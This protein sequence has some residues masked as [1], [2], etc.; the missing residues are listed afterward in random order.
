MVDLSTNINTDNELCQVDMSWTYKTKNFSP[1]VI[2]N[3]YTNKNYY[4][5]F[6]RQATYTQIYFRIPQQNQFPGPMGS[7]YWDVKRY[8]RVGG[9]NTVEKWRI[10]RQGNSGTDL[11]PPNIKGTLTDKT[12][13]GWNGVAFHILGDGQLCLDLH[14]K[15]FLKQDELCDLSSMKIPY[16]GNNFIVA[17]DSAIVEKRKNFLYPTMRRSLICINSATSISQVTKFIAK[18]NELG[19]DKTMKTLTPRDTVA[20]YS[21][22]T[23]TKVNLNAASC[24]L[25]G[26]QGIYID[27]SNND[28]IGRVDS[29]SI[30]VISENP[31]K[32]QYS[33]YEYLP[34]DVVHFLHYNNTYNV[35]V[36]FDEGGMYIDPSNVHGIQTYKGILEN[37]S[38]LANN[39][40]F[41]MSL[42]KIPYTGNNFIVA[43]KS[44]IRT[45]RITE[46]NEVYRLNPMIAFNG[47]ICKTNELGLDKTISGLSSIKENVKVRQISSTSDI[48]LSMNTSGHSPKY[49]ITSTQAFYMKFRDINKDVKIKQHVPGVAN[50]SWFNNNMAF[51]IRFIEQSPNK[52]NLLA[53][54]G[55]GRPSDKDF[56]DGDSFSYRGMTFYFDASGVFTNGTNEG[57]VETTVN[58]LG[59]LKIP[60]KDDETTLETDHE[61]IS[62][63]RRRKFKDIF[64][65]N[66]DSSSFITK[67]SDIGINTTV[68]GTTPKTNV[69]VFRRFVDGDDKDKY[70]LIN[71]DSMD[72]IKI[73]QGIYVDLSDNN[74]HAH[75]SSGKNN[76]DP[77]DWSDGYMYERFAFKLSSTN[78][79]RYRLTQYD[80]Y[81]IQFL[82]KILH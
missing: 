71:M 20:V 64:N 74:D 43:E 76:S 45:K 62:K 4:L 9:S 29:V 8:Q 22:S 32:Y 14:Y 36:E 2:A 44:A 6:Q 50:S 7:Y 3:N 42:A 16:T 51:K 48:D 82:I 23:N 15:E 46:L 67:S 55:D 30:K 47:F 24:D 49:D 70:D 66:L 80:T 56:V 26:T 34:G 37:G 79:P 69:K 33:S 65:I 18:S 17:T 58:D 60:F 40:L 63:K 39:M 75:F 1:T 31:K 27:M 57:L 19:L 53:I 28:D 68:S 12:S 81:I 35:S 54:S 59:Y 10:E 5:Y 21:N 25:S 52:Y 61:K 38:A 41:D 72:T 11:T 13:F 78:P 77:Q 73:D